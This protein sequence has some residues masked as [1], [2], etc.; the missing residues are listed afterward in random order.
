MKS[1]SFTGPNQVGGRFFFAGALVTVLILCGDVGF[2]A[3][4]GVPGPPVG[5][6]TPNNLSHPAVRAD[7]VITVDH[8]WNPPLEAPVLGEHYSYGCDAPETLEQFSYPNTSCVDKLDDPGTYYDAET[9][10]AEGMPCEGLEVY[11]HHQLC[12][13]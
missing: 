9:C 12:F 11:I 2:A 6:E 4:G 8:R 13:G 7:S 10:T 3:K 1:R 5:G